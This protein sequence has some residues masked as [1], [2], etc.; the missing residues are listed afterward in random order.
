MRPL[1]GWILWALVVGGYLGAALW[2]ARARSRP[3]SAASRS[4][5]IAIKGAVLA[6]GWGVVTYLLNQNRAF[7]GA[8]AAARACPTRCRSCSCV[9][10]VAQLALT[11]TAWGRHVYAVGGNTEA[12]RRA[13]INVVVGQDQL[14]RRLLGAR[15]L[16]RRH[17]ARLA[18]ATR[19]ARRRAA[20]TPCCAPSAPPRSAA[21]ACSAAAASCIYPVVGGLVVA[22]IDNGLGLIGKVGPDRL[23]PV[24]A[25]VHRA[26]TRAA[27]RRVRRRALPQARRRDGLI[28][29][30]GAPATR[31]CTRASTIPGDGPPASPPRDAARRGCR[32]ARRRRRGGRV[33]GRRRG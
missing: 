1:L 14:L 23:H 18:A 24:G 16:P 10:V 5:S 11:R 7:A 12:A 9:V 28:E 22:T 32:R 15:R 26:G 29:A 4:A 8:T 27:P 33:A 2:R 6:V 30:P 19:S 17:G 3:G 13:G 21:S 31:R 25:E 20:T